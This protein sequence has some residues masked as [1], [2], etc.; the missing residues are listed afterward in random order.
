MD[1]A[2]TDRLRDRHLRARMLGAL[3]A[4]RGFREPSLAGDVLTR[5]VDDAVS[6]DR[7]FASEEHAWALLR[8]LVQLGLATA[9]CRQL[10]RFERENLADLQ[11]SI[12]AKGVALI[13]QLIPAEPLVE[14]ERTD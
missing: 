10:R 7:K 3:Y 6:A 14:D 2:H 8:D 13:D 1:R 12:T 4:A 11:C 5:I 9:P